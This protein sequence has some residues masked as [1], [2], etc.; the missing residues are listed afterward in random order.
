MSFLSKLFGKKDA[1]QI[2]TVPEKVSLTVTGNVSY[3]TEIPSLQGDYAKTV[4]LWAHD[5]ASP[6]RKQ[7]EYARYFC[8]NVASETL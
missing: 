7:D 1:S 4:F 2:E 8:M 6:V 3:S 5:K